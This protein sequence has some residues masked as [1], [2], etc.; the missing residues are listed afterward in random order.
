MI[1]RTC[2]A[3]IALGALLSACASPRQQAISRQARAAERTLQ[4]LPTIGDPGLVAAADIAFAKQARDEG[5]WTAFRATA[6][7]GAVVHG[8]NGPVPVEVFV[9]GRADPAESV[10]WTPRDI[11]SSCD[12]TLAVT[13]GRLQT[14]SGEVG[15]YLT[16]WELQP[17][18]GYKWVYDIGA[19]DDPQPAPPDESELP[20]DAIIVP[21]L[22]GI[23]GRV[24]TCA[25]DRPQMSSPPLK[26][27]TSA[28]LQQG[29]Y[30][31]DDG[32][33]KMTWHHT[34]IGSRV[35][36]VDWFRDGEWQS[37]DTFFVP[38]GG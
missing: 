13:L 34:E 25:A 1:G 16:V 18:R 15:T 37:A 35:A 36:Y 19:L 29:E 38:P 10:A 17:D 2:I 23:N 30:R 28:A 20:E 6:A 24:A 27:G 4:R 5:M 33:L 3:A 21:G 11:W 9:T 22:L 12:G 26:T 7:T 14:P 8:V 32:T 31:S